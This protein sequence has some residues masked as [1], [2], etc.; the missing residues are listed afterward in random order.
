M[1]VACRVLADRTWPELPG[2][3][4][5]WRDLP[6][7]PREGVADELYVK[8]PRG[9]TFALVPEVHAIEESAAGLTVTPSIVAPSG[10]Y[11]GFLTDGVW[12]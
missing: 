5:W 4:S 6:R 11:H 1:S 2:Q 12:T 9:V 7:P 3:V 10:G 8:D